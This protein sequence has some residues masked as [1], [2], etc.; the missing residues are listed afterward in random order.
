MRANAKEKQLK[1]LSGFLP[2]FLSMLFITCEDKYEYDN[3]EPDWLGESIYDYLKNDGNFTY[4]VRI[5]DAVED[6]GVKYSEVL[7]KTGNKTIFV[8]DDKAFE[9]FFQENPYGIRNFDQ[10]SNSQQR[11]ILFAGI[12]DDTFLL[13][14][15]SSAAGTG[16]APPTRGQSMRKM[17]ALAIEDSIPFEIGDELP[18]TPYW[19]RFKEKG[20]H[21]LKDNS[22]WTLV[23]FLPSQMSQKGITD[24]DFNYIT[25]AARQ[26]DDAYIYDIKVIRRDITCKNGYINVLE[27]VL[28]PADNMA[29]YIRKNEDTRVFSS[30]LERFCAPY[31]ERMLLSET[32]NAVD[33]LFEK[34]YFTSGNTRDPDNK[35]KEGLLTFDPGQNTYSPT[36]LETDMGAMF[37]PTDRA[38]TE[39]FNAGEGKFL[40]D[41]YGSWENIPD[42]VLYHLINNHMR[43]SFLASVPS[44]FGAL[45][46]KI[47]TSLGIRP[48]DIVYAKVCT[49]GVVY[50]VDKVY[51]PSEYASVMA[52]IITGDIT[53]IFNWAVKTYQFDLY[54]LSMDNVFSFFVPTDEVMQNYIHQPKYSQ[55][56]PEK[57]KFWYNTRTAQVN[58]TVYSL[59]TGDSIRTETSGSNLEY[60]MK[61]ILDNHIV[62]GEIESGKKYYTTK[63]GATIQISGNEGVGMKLE[64][65]GNKTLNENVTVTEAYSMK[66][67]KTYLV[68]H[69]IQTPL[70][71]VYAVMNANTDFREF[72][73]LC[74]NSLPYEVQE[75][76]KT[77]VYGGSIFTREGIDFNVGFFNTFNYTVYIPTNEAVQEAIRSGVIKTWEQIAALPMEER[78]EET[79]KLYNLLRYHFQDNSVYISGERVEKSY[80]TATLNKDT[81]KFYKLTLNGNGSNLELTTASG[82]KAAVVTSSALY[83]ISC[84]DYKF[85]TAGTQIETSSY[86][87]VHQIDKVLE[88][89][90]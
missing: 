46:D 7:Q 33:S 41:R 23:H 85:N 88:Y 29:E 49:N 68:D 39:Y 13:E 32:G 76:S 58:A 62:V 79:E 21:V 3:S 24:Q 56:V 59:L 30:L 65:G 54:L 12:L 51:P 36:G 80:E 28:Y 6:N 60:A 9:V 10:L 72:A 44:R 52:P 70:Q 66:N 31:Y 45:E 61:D 47:G 15:M 82:G 63:G 43:Q 67:G 35:V 77:L 22:R 81:E 26:G 74:I 57:W 87:V 64:G 5:I 86:A 19:E 75:G 17:T 78:A 83:N 11:A 53:R 90:Q 84:R 73:D 37:I 18:N 42:N 38:L 89:K 34:R 20:I 14:M 25:G 55:A 69:I 50:V 4:Y 2:L 8:A 27:K 1:K 40:K 48:E 16:D 71:S